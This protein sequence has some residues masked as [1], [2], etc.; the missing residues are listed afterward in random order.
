MFVIFCVKSKLMY[1]DGYL[2]KITNRYPKDTFSF[3]T[4]FLKTD[5]NKVG[6]AED[7]FIFSMALELLH[8]NSSREKKNRAY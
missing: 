5:S 2:S 7:D 3:F 8:S 1:K 4:L 6:N